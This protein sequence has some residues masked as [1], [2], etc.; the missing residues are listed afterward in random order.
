VE[1]DTTLFDMWGT[2][3]LFADNDL[4]ID[5]SEIAKV[6]NCNFILIFDRRAKKMS[7]NELLWLGAAN[8]EPTRDIA[9][10]NSTLVVDARP[11]C[12]KANDENPSRWPN[13]VTAD[14]ATIALVDKR[15][16]DYGIGEFIPS[17]SERYSTLKLSEGA[18][19]VN[20]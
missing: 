11:K 1:A 8:T 5:T 19:W 4:A 13:I 12:P 7:S 10:C 6:S 20:S 16:S 3:L 18:E 2:L 15:W 14:E 9:L 17:P